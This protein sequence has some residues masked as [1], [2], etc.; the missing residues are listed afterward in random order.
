MHRER[1]KRMSLFFCQFLIYLPT[2]VPFCPIFSY[3][4]KIGHLLK[5]SNNYY[6]DL[7]LPF[8]DHLTIS[9]GQQFLLLTWRKMRNFG[10]R[11]PP[12]LVHILTVI[13]SPPYVKY[14]WFRRKNVTSWKNE[15]AFSST[16]MLLK[17]V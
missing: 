17:G 5:V 1:S 3:I 12:H 15:V 7:V 4:P 10:P 13:E 2:L 9:Q 16:Q 11:F 8:F 14:G 6:V